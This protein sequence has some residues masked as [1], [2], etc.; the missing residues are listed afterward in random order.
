MG[1]QVAIRTSDTVIAR[2]TV[3]GPASLRLVLRTGGEIVLEC[4]KTAGVRTVFGII[5]V[6]NIPIFD[7]LA[8]DGGVRLVP[9]RG[10]HGAA[11]MADGYVRATGRPA[12]VITSTGVGAANAAGPLL[13]AFV[14]SS[15]VL[16]ITGQVDAAYIE[17]DRAPLHGAKDQLSMLDRVGKAAF[18]AARTEDIASVMRQAVRLAR[19]GRPGPV[20]VEI[21]I[22]QQYR[23]VEAEVLPFE[24]P[25]PLAPDPTALDRAAELIGRARRPLMWA[26]GGVISSGAAPALRSLAERIGAGVLTSAAGRGSLPE[27]H[28]QCL[29]YFTLDASVGELLEHADLLLAV[30]TRLRGNETRGWQLPLPTPRIQIDVEAELIGRNY[31]VDVG[32]VADARMALEAL[33]RNV[34]R[35]PQS[36]WL[37][38][39]AEARQAARTR[40]RATLGPYERILD[41]LRSTL[42]RDAIV[43]RDVTIPASTWGGRLLEVYAP[44]TALHS[45]TYA[46]GLGL[47]MGIGA[48]IGQPDRQVVVLAGDGGF[49]SA[50]AELATA[51]QERV[52]LTVV[53]FNDGGYGILR[54]LQDAHFDGRRFGVDLD[55]PDYVELGRSFGMWAGQ[56]RSSFELRPQLTEA[57]QQAGPAL[58][59][60]DMAAVGPTAVPFTGAARLVPG[61]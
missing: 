47:S 1:D 27:D 13:E 42:E 37:G 36:K 45:A 16:H 32:I 39:V 8:R 60:V 56:V 19:S 46:I 26:G 30:G 12:A 20:S 5:S 55:T 57:L 38:Q 41:D 31:D 18:R 9:T 40:M 4:L 58:L 59:E 3:S 23:S 44:R 53:L 33:A 29:G 6:H 17:G 24:A 2:R 34:E 51:S 35:R 49:A 21:P 50:M 7:A 15:P 22:D 43:V 25:R 52:R 61:R 10:E 28:A 48:S 11:S 14:A 54:N